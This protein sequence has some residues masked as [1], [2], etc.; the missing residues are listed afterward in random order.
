MK[1][2]ECTDVSLGYLQYILYTRSITMWSMIS[3]RE[4]VLIRAAQSWGL[5]LV[6]HSWGAVCL[7]NLSIH[8]S[9][10][11]PSNS[12]QSHFEGVP[13]VLWVSKSFCECLQFALG[14][15]N[16]WPR[17]RGSWATVL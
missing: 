14:L 11:S 6:K 8:V 12:G 2:R 9:L 1:A 5:C 7:H 17:P 10:H 15:S 16:F 3:I 4:H 13:F